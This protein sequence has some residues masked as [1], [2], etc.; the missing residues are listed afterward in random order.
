VKTTQSPAVGD[1]DIYL[2]LSKVM[3]LGGG[4]A[5]P[6]FCPKGEGFEDVA[7]VPADASGCAWNIVS[8]AGNAAGAERSVGRDGYL[9]RDRAGSLYRLLVIEH[10]VVENPAEPGNVGSVTFDLLPVD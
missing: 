5:E 10:S 8:L 4:G 3:S 6:P 7:D 1:A 2:R 9:T